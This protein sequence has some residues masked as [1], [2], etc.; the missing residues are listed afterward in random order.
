MESGP[1]QA[2][3]EELTC[4]VCMSYLTDP[5]TI[6]CGHS[7]C[8][9]CLHLS[10]E[11]SQL[12]VQCPTCREPS[13]QED[14]RTSI[15]LKKLVSIARQAGLMKYLSSEEHQC[16]THK[17]TKG[18]FCTENRIYLCQLCSDSHEHR[19]HRHCPIEAA[20]EGQ[21]ERLLKQMES[22]W[23]KIQDNEENLEAE[24]RMI[25]LWKNCLIL[26]EETIR[27]EYR[28]CYPDLSEQEEEHIACMKE[29]G[30]YYLEKLME[31]EAMM[32]QKDKQLRD[33]YQ[34]LMAMSQ[35]PYVVLLQDFDDIFRRSKS[36]QLIKPLAMKPEIYVLAFNGLGQIFT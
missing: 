16:V 28:T 13:Q 8:R 14:F 12:P 23:K 24:R 10:W 26:R 19:G 34:E 35:E 2:F 18:I 5:V 33:M 11:D 3:R 15:V 36:M 1:S 29:E 7:F 25:T 17:E 20:A 9:A 6:S 31:S 32:V 22:L 4:F 30:N 21:M 27:A